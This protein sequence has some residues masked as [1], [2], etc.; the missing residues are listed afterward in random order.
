[1]CDLLVEASFAVNLC[2]AIQCNKNIRLVVITYHNCNC[3]IAEVIMDEI[4]R[5]LRSSDLSLDDLGCILEVTLA[6]LRAAAATH[7][8]TA[9]TASNNPPRAENDKA[10]DSTQRRPT[11]TTTPERYRE[12]EMKNKALEEENSRLRREVKDKDDDIKSLQIEKL[13]LEAEVFGLQLEIE[14]LERKYD[15]LEK[16]YQACR[17][18]KSAD[19]DGRITELDDGD[20]DVV[21]LKDDANWKEVD[22]DICI[23]ESLSMEDTVARR[24]KEAEAN[25]DVIQ[26]DD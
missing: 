9:T 26:I 8:L 25:G 23:G 13:S 18:E 19:D 24:R 1:M 22:D 12:L 21:D 5:E 2:N 6:D 15:E 7:D 14:T 10:D 4:T 11:P 16:D 20:P 17:A 3:T